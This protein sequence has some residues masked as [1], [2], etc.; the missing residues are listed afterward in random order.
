MPQPSRT[1]KVSCPIEV[2]LKADESPPPRGV[3]SRSILSYELGEGR[4]WQKDFST[5]GKG[6]VTHSAEKGLGI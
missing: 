3:F 1:H 5:F 2:G 6:I 4:C